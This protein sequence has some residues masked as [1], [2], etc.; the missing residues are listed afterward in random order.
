MTTRNISARFAWC[1]LWLA[2][3]MPPILWSTPN[4]AIVRAATGTYRYES[5]DG[6]TPRGQERFQL[7]VHPDGTRTMMMWHDLTAKGAQFTVVLTVDAG[8][9]PREAYVKYW[10]DGRY[11]GSTFFRREGDIMTGEADGAAGRRSQRV[12]LPA[13]FS[14]GTHP[15]A[16]DGWHTANADSTRSGVQEVALLSLEAGSDVTKPILGQI[17]PLKVERLGEESVTVPAG[18]FATTHYRLAGINDIWVTG[19]DLLVVKSE[20]P[21]RGLRYSLV[22]FDAR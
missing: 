1:S 22:E 20:I 14:M 4:A 3:L 5:M 11:K 7:L 19:P 13:R 10:N 18:T 15:V 17:V 21:A 16:G 8:F 9:Q 2:A 12:T 6:G